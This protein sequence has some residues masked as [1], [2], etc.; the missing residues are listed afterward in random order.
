MKDSILFEENRSFFDV[1]GQW[2]EN[3]AL[4]PF[5]INWHYV[6]FGLIFALFSVFFLKAVLL[7]FRRLTRR[8][9]RSQSLRNG[10]F[11]S[12]VFACFFG[13][14]LIYLIG[15]DHDGTSKN[16]IALL[17]RSV[18]SSFEMFLSKS[19]LIGVAENCKADPVYMT[20]FAF[21]HAL[22]V[23]LS[24]SFAVACFSKRIK[25]WLRSVWWGRIAHND[26]TC[27]FWG[28]NERSYMLAR[29]M[30][31]KAGGNDRIVF[32]D[33]PDE[34]EKENKSQSFSSLIG[35]LSFKLRI[36]RQIEDIS[37]VLFRSSARPS[38]ISGTD[39]DF[40][41]DLDLL[42]LRRILRRSNRKLH[43]VFAENET[44]N[45]R[46]AV[47][48]LD[49]PLSGEN[50][51]VYC[52]TRNTRLAHLIEEKYEGRLRIVDDSRLAVNSLKKGDVEHSYPIDYVAVNNDNAVVESVF[53]ALIIGF[54]TTGQDAL[55][56]LY[57]FSAFPAPDGT[58][59]KVRIHVVDN[60]MNALR[61]DFLQ[62]VPAMEYLEGDGKEIVLHHMDLGSR[63]YFELQKS[64][65]KELNYA[66]IAAG[67]DE[68]N[69][70]IAS[71]LLEMA[72]QY[73]D[74][75][76]S[77]FRVFVRLYK[78]V[79]KEKFDAA[80]E[81]YKPFSMP[82]AYFGSARTLYTKDNIVDNYLKAAAEDFH[83]S[84]CDANASEVYVPLEKRLEKERMN[85]KVGPLY[86]YR[87]F[88]RKESQNEAN[89]M[90]V[91]TKM[92][93][94]GLTENPNAVVLPRWDKSCG[95]DKSDID[96]MLRKRL[97]NASICEHLRWNASHLMMGYLPM[98]PEVRKQT[99]GTCNIRA[100]QHSCIVEW[101]KLDM[102][103]QGYDYFVVKTSVY[104]YLK[105]KVTVKIDS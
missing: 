33:F 17:L 55:R 68:R 21:V 41:D 11:Y 103:T 53:T 24:A 5:G 96:A 49:A 8:G 46:A 101:N 67:D 80:V 81:V 57:E 61:G 73:K 70:E 56:F 100:K 87:S 7:V 97:I 99:D 66:V 43:F 10:L 36:I 77:R 50:T 35:L 34:N 27:V 38:E 45:L 28:L 94:M 89:S 59:S 105:G 71:S 84:Y 16:I 64:L 25:Y 85:P 62:E 14:V 76:L 2:I 47:N 12:L 4:A 44:F 32:V 93:L 58:K 79:N 65:V 51:V 82:L 26:T 52:A 18:L 29:D 40:F 92:R 63:E 74:N 37:Y 3:H 23:V 102:S 75:S 90:H 20:L 30:A 39:N 15:Y 42:T 95:L 86:A 54:G 13:G 60:K 22:A 104:Q 31:H 19:N 88:E 9:A 98:S 78:E 69:I 91:Y 72:N 48:I 6:L 83:K 1:V